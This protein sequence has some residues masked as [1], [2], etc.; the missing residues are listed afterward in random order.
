MTQILL[1][2]GSPD[3]RHAHDIRLLAGRLKVAEHP[4]EVAFLEHGSPAPAQ[5]AAL[6]AGRHQR[7]A[8][9]VP[10]LLAMSWR[11]RADLA[12]A[13]QAMS[14]A[15][16]DLAIRCAA[17]IGAHPLLLAGVGELLAQYPL[18]GLVRP[19]LVLATSG[20][21]A[22]RARLALDELVASHGPLLA[23]AHG[24]A[25]VRVAHLDGGR[26]IWPVRTLLQHIDGARDVV[27]LPLLLTDGPARDRV[28]AAGHRVDCPVLPGT[29]APTQALADLV[30]LR[31]AHAPLAQPSR[32]APVLLP[33]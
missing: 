30:V 1:G 33:G 17:P 13:T 7:Q 24:L 16:P 6:L 28:V 26:P 4:A 5:L 2:A 19:G 29:L 8:T 32:P 18:T 12:R 11:M 10:L 9:V 21:R 14:Q 22:P 3:P 23:S 27:V 31:A 15:A 20:L 25:G